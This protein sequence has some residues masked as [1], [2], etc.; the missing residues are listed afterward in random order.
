M[1]AKLPRLTVRIQIRKRVRM[2][3]LFDFYVLHGPR[4]RFTL[5]HASLLFT[6]TFTF[7]VCCSMLCRIFFLLCQCFVK[8]CCRLACCGTAFSTRRPPLWASGF[9]AL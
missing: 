1:C 3:L 9:S 8:F 5:C 6:C 7:V 4:L 2:A